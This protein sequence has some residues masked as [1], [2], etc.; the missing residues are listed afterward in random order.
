VPISGLRCRTCG[1]CGNGSRLP[2]CILLGTHSRQ[3]IHGLC[4]GCSHNDS[5]LMTLLPRMQLG[6][7]ALIQPLADEHV[8]LRKSVHDTVKN[9]ILEAGAEV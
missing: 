4:F 9:G 3:A 8:Q 5:R 1:C 6:L 2:A 7:E